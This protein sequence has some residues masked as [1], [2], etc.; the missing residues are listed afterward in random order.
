MF[1]NKTVLTGMY[2]GL[3]CSYRSQIS[4][5][6]EIRPRCIHIGCHVKCRRLFSCELMTF[7]MDHEHDVFDKSDKMPLILFSRVRNGW[8]KEATGQPAEALTHIRMI[9]TSLFLSLSI[10][11]KCVASKMKLNSHILPN[12][13]GCQDWEEWYFSFWWERKGQQGAADNK[14]EWHCTGF[15]LS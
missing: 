8:H 3:D 1:F 7:L 4:N 12:A 2:C 5:I 6:C 13:T 11:N 9:N 15:A 14:C 10:I